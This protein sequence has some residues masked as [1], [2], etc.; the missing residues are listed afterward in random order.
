MCTLVFLHLNFDQT[1]QRFSWLDQLLF[2]D[3]FIAE[4]IGIAIFGLLLLRKKLVGRL[5]F[6]LLLTIYCFITTVQVSSI[7]IGGEFLTRLAVENINHISLMVT[8]R[9]IGV[10]FLSLLLLTIT[11][12]FL[13]FGGYSRKH[14]RRSSAAIL[15]LLII[16]IAI[17][18][19]SDLLPSDTVVTRDAIGDKNHLEYSSPLYKFYKTFFREKTGEYHQKVRSLL[20][21]EKQFL[22]AQGYSLNQTKDYPFIKDNYYK[23][24]LAIEEVT[25][26]SQP[27]II[28]FF[29]EGVSTN[30]NNAYHDDMPMLTPNLLEFSK[31]SMRVEDY[32]GH[33]AATD[34]GL[35]GQICS[36]YPFHGGYG[37][38]D[39]F[40][41]QI[42]KPPY[43]SLNRVLEEEGYSTTF[44]DVH[45]HDKSYVDEMMYH[46]GFN[47]VITGDILLEKHLDG[48]GSI[49]EDSMSDKQFYRSLVSLLKSREG[50][51]KQPMFMGIYTLG[52]HAFRLPPSD[53]EIFGNGNNEVLNRVHTLD[54]GFGLFWEYFKSSSYAEDTI[55]IFTSDHA[56]YM[57]KPYVAA[58]NE[59]GT[60]EPLPNFWAP[61]PLII[62][63]PTRELPETYSAGIRTSIDFAPSL[64]H[65]LGV[66]NRK[67]AF[68]GES[69]FESPANRKRT[70]GILSLETFTVINQKG[71]YFTLED[72]KDMGATVKLFHKYVKTY[73]HY[74]MKRAIWPETT[75]PNTEVTF[76]SP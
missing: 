50:K 4:A 13:E 15:S 24:A 29:T 63:D 65:Y 52:T 8:P 31:H 69:I 56:P 41:E 26:S 46:I 72:S 66:E 18:N 47:E 17:G 71:N 9:V 10:I 76:S 49:N 23:G 14:S 57:E 55:V 48:E 34:R 38:W 3:R 51:L 22:I 12:L 67:N 75:I 62:Y 27:N 2:L 33:T 42:V 43:N 1:G 21:A 45:I 54:K 74:E 64:L 6:Y 68:L 59:L 40:Y 19:S 11:I 7:Y 61:I 58:L 60:A 28:V 35:L 30:L 32:H 20:P 36:A 37:G 25:R 16:T 53:T 44:L 73:Q 39:S 5:I 70:Y